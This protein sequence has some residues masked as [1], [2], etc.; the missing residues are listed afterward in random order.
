MISLLV[1]DLL[2]LKKSIW[3]PFLYSFMVIFMFSKTDSSPLMIYVMGINMISYLLIMYSTAYDDLSKSDIML[4]S[5]PMNRRDIVNE[6]YLSI[7]V[8]IL[9]SSILMGFS[10]GIMAILG[11]SENIRMIRL[12]DVGIAAGSLSILV[13]LYLPVYFKLGYVKAK[14]VN[15]AVFFA[16]FF[17]PT[18][19]A[20]LLLKS[21][22][23]EFGEKLNS[24][25]EIQV[26]LI[27]LAIAVILGIIS[28]SLSVSFY[29]KRE[30]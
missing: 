2:L 26:V 11:L 12:S 23:I 16:V 14:L 3:L 27:I 17:V 18:L 1:K 6:R 29:Q 19:L 28:Y 13:F 5:L 22:S 8:F 15:F 4:N 9:G 25:P 10:G 30:F 7:F 24:L 20:R 21:T